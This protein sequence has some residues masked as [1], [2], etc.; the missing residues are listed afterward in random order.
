MFLAYSGLWGQR[1]T[2]QECCI[3]HGILSRKGSQE[4]NIP[5]TPNKGK[6]KMDSRGEG[7]NLWSVDF[8]LDT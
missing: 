7:L 5:L 2:F 1:K 8:M 4:E 3:R 6:G